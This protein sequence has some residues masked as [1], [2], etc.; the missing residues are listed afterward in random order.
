MRDI[1]QLIVDLN[2]DDNVA[3]ARAGTTLTYGQLHSVVDQLAGDLSAAL[4]DDERCVAIAID[5]SI[6]YVIALL[7]VIKL[8]KAFI[9]LGAN[10]PS[11]R[12]KRIVERTGLRTII[13]LQNDTFGGSWQLGDKPL[14]AGSGT[15]ALKSFHF[16]KHPLTHVV[17]SLP[18]G[19][20]YILST[21]GST[22]E[23]KLILGSIVGLNHFIRWEV[24]RF[25][26][27]GGMRT[28]FLSPVTFDVSLRDILV[29]LAAGATL[30]IPSEEQRLD[31]S[32]LLHWLH[33]HQ[34]NLIHIVPTLFRG[35]M[36][37]VGQ[38][39][40]VKLL[41]E[42]R[43]ALLAGEALY[44]A[45]VNR[46]LEVMGDNTQLVNVYGP[47]E[48]TLA[49]LYYVIPSGSTTSEAIIPLGRPL[50]D[51]DLFILNESGTAIT[52][53]S[54]G[55]LAISTAYRSLGY[56]NPTDEQQIAFTTLSINGDE[57]DI[58]CTGDL[59]HQDAEGL[60]HF[61]ARKDHQIK[62][63]GQ[64]IE[65]NAIESVLGQHKDIE[66]CVV[67]VE[68]DVS[69]VQTLVA[70]IVSPQAQAL[71]IDTLRAFVA[72][73]LPEYM[74]PARFI[75]LPHLPINSNGKVDRKQ[76]VASSVRERPHLTVHY[77]AA[78]T[79][80]EKQ[81][82]AIWCSLL[83]LD[84][85][86][87]DD[88]FFDL[89][90]TSL[91]GMR[92]LPEMRQQLGCSISIAEFFESAT[93]RRLAQCVDRKQ[94]AVTPTK[95]H[96]RKPVDNKHG[97]IA[98][99]G[100]ACRVPDGDN[101]DQFWNNLVEAKESIRFFSNDEL[102]ASV[103]AELLTQSNYVKACGVINH[104]DC[105][106]SDFFNMAEREADILDPQ[107]RILIELSHA[108][109][110]DAGINPE[111]YEGLIGVFAGVGDNGYFTR[112]LLHHP[113]SNLLGEHRLRLANEKDYVAPR[114][115]YSLNLNG[116]AISVHTACST[117]LVA[118]AQGVQSLR[119]GNSDVTLCGGA[120]IPCPLLSGYV[121]ADGGFASADG[122]CRPFDAD[123]SG[124]VFSAGAGVV[125][126]KRL[127]DAI[128]AGD[129]IYSVIKGVGVNNDGGGKMSFMA[130]SAQGQS[131]A[132]A[133][134][135]NDANLTPDDVSYIEAH[136]TATPLGDPIEVEALGHIYSSAQHEKRL[137]SVKSNLGH[138][139][140]A[141]GVIGFIKTVLSLHHKVIPASINYQQ[142]NPNID[143]T[144][145]GFS[146][147]Q[148]LYPL[149]NS[150]KPYCAAVSAFGVGGTNAH[151]ILQQWQASHIPDAG[152]NTSRPAELLLFSAKSSDSL[153][154][155]VDNHREY[156]DK[157]RS[158]CN[159]AFTQ[160]LGRQHFNQRAFAVVTDIESAQE[161][162]SQPT[163]LAAH[164]GR[165]DL[166][167]HMGS[168][169]VAFMFPGQGAQYIDMATL[170]YADE[171]RFREAVDECAQQLHSILNV[172]IREIIYPVD[173]S[174]AAKRIN[175]TRYSQPAL[176]TIGYSLACWWKSIGVEPAAMIGHSIGE[177]IAACLAG[178]FS[179]TDAL[180]LVAMRG[181][182]M[183]EQPGGAMLSAPLS[184][185][186]LNGW[187]TDLAIGESCSIAAVNSASR[188]VASGAYSAI[189]KLKERLAKAGVE[190]KT[191]KTSH[192]FH[193]AM[194]Q[195]I[196]EPFKTLVNSVT[197][198]KPNVPIMST[199]TG[200]WLSD[201]QATDPGYWASHLRK[202]VLF[203][204]AVSSLWEKDDY[205][206]LELGPRSSA[207][208]LARQ[209]SQNPLK[210][211]AIPSLADSAGEDIN[212]LLG[213]LGK[214][215]AEGVD[216]N[217]QAFYE[218]RSGRR[219]SMPTYPF[220]RKVHWL[221]PHASTRTVMATAHD[222]KSEKFSST[223]AVDE[224]FSVTTQDSVTRI[225]SQMSGIDIDQNMSTLSFFELGLDSLS[226]TQLSVA[227][228]QQLGADISLRLLTG[229]YSTIS[230][231]AAYIKTQDIAEQVID[232]DAITPLPVI[233]QPYIVDH[234]H[235]PIA[236]ARLGRD[237]D[238]N[239]GW[240]I[241]KPDNPE[242]Y[243]LVEPL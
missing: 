219:I 162:L 191:L 228:K 5:A 55:E 66:Q 117:S 215:W 229:E 2:G 80:I 144:T 92:L 208:Q 4:A 65:I 211:I 10:Y 121:Y 19:L 109:L 42:L 133:L 123:A 124:T 100:I 43:Y 235:A 11:Q 134:A 146:V 136:G 170:L 140:A 233:G 72:E 231:L 167:M 88:N 60:I 64:R 240:Y 195:P 1:S 243:F 122:H 31:A 114:I 232:N 25:K 165:R 220:T 217:W 14:A 161:R 7:A 218:A 96:K 32:Q 37:A 138:L 113:V 61:H 15:M 183:Q 116:P 185:A 115:A 89:G 210:Q 143:F 171:P 105:F 189:D 28:S 29:P 186:D 234:S 198:N 145:L 18:E 175:E 154:R 26:L 106:D 21:S 159:I 242:Q 95:A 102:S 174:V 86:G 180:K 50:P 203:A 90:G 178:V 192:A 40:D 110:E 22:G 24:E 101:P 230:S 77:V 202:P 104:H 149:N 205:I 226:M 130:P 152:V 157:D 94:Q 193:S 112:N 224:N 97:D 187:I 87:I 150:E 84:Q 153:Q 148:H 129:P 91:L 221:E 158:L 131:A 207:S 93:I 47:S 39:T 199:A 200:Q 125:V 147:N 62:L 197:L 127:E 30:Y 196:V 49:K 53:G 206:L 8:D 241:A 33:E 73:T 137:G 35:L 99:V 172:D 70:H 107:Q 74:V 71:A 23:P 182:M 56:L 68:G 57:H 239:P 135:L 216:I 160:A 141:G 76:L 204:K 9:P 184:Q 201:E 168:T 75:F 69:D 108:A 85:A 156:F 179:L 213:A 118:I 126:L 51:T 78:Q 41:P 67:H 111:G 227:L 188:C 190:C 173:T 44:Q 52:D 236:G 27:A 194:M 20:G 79:A 82:T 142:P 83:R 177:Y 12:L 169:P 103:D 34:I 59:V 139:D 212:V 46:W 209:Q 225:V 38:Q 163:Y 119:E 3:I 17:D 16:F 222:K 132:I 155:Q 58:Y 214:L 166:S 223:A 128:A 63:H 164:S 45:D 6:E 238:G 48:T 181:A 151:V 98:V 81:L 36:Q 13:S 54:I 176:F 120:Y 237:R